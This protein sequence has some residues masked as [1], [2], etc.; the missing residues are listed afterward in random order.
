MINEAKTFHKWLVEYSCFNIDTF[1]KTQLKND[2]YTRLSLHYLKTE[3]LPFENA[4][5]RYIT[6]ILDISF[7][8]KGSSIWLL[9][10]YMVELLTFIV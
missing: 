10:L 6:T 2:I 9:T 5:T 1:V 4:Y 8:C 7:L 3:N